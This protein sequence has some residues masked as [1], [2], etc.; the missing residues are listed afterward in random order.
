MRA[1]R[2]IVPFVVVPFVVVPLVGLAAVD[3]ADHRLAPADVVA[4]IGDRQ[5]RYAEF[6]DYLEAQVG[7]Q[8]QQ[9]ES[10]VLSGLL[11]EF[12]EERCLRAA[13][14]EDGLV[15]PSATRQQIVRAAVESRRRE[16]VSD[17]EIERFY[18]AHRDRFERPE[19]LR[20]R[21]I[22]VYERADAERALERLRAG[23]AFAAVAADLSIDPAAQ[24]GGDQG[25]LALDDLPPAFVEPIA[26]LAEE[27]VSSVIATEYG[28]HIFQLVDRQPGSIL[29]LPEARDE[30]VAEL[31]RKRADDLLRLVV[32]DAADRYNVAVLARNVP[33]DYQGK[34]SSGR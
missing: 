15:P 21:Q 26:G 17:S 14:I 13:A 8:G 28:F 22:L 4:T 16:A 19:R 31:D 6:E 18:A 7:D 29:R 24:H 9:L 27:Q 32:A 12:L 30:I 23:E 20:L 10:R 11:D 1:H 3:C 5:L 25:Y 2:T 33:F 34:F